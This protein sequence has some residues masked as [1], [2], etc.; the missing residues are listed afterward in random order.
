MVEVRLDRVQRIVVVNDKEI[1]LTP[2]EFRL[3]SVLVS[4]EGEVLTRE[5]LRELVW[6][7]VKSLAP[8]QVKLY[9]SYLRKKLD[10]D[11]SGTPIETVRGAGYRYTRAGG[12]PD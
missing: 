2:L 8:E 11:G 4:H 10:L 9:V 7:D 5:R 12:S 6:N 1:S 3:L